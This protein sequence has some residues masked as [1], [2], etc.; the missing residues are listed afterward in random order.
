MHTWLSTRP[1]KQNKYPQGKTVGGNF[2]N[3]ISCSSFAKTK[4][5]WVGIH[6][7]YLFICLF[8]HVVGLLS[9]TMWR[10][11]L[12][13]YR[14]ARQ[15][16]FCFSIHQKAENSL[17]HFY[18]GYRLTG[19]KKHNS[20]GTGARIDGLGTKLLGNKCKIYNDDIKLKC[21]H[22]LYSIYKTSVKM[23]IFNLNRQH[24]NTRSNCCLLAT[25]KWNLTLMGDTVCVLLHHFL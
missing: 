25:A 7:I 5:L 11:F 21:T 22:R 12:V 9:H 4:E 16:N 13:D 23:Y 18:S 19:T 6:F 14:A 17:S 20:A 3:E 10:F 15:M 2:A 8:I 24:F 1:H